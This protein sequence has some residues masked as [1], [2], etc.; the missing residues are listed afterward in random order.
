MAAITIDVTPEQVATM[1][2][3]HEWYGI[4]LAAYDKTTAVGTNGKTATVKK[5]TASKAK[6]DPIEDETEAD[7]DSERREELTGSTLKELKQEAIDLG[8][9]TAKE[10]VGVKKDDLIEMI[11]AAELDEDDDDSDDEDEDDDAADDDDSDADDDTDD[12]EGPTEEEL[13]E[14]SARELR[15]YAKENYGPVAKEE[16]FNIVKASKEDLIEFILGGEDEDADDDDDADSDDD[17]DDDTDD[18]DGDDP[19]DDEDALTEEDLNEMS[20]GEL[21]K[22]LKEE[23]GGKWT[24][25]DTKEVLIKKIIDTAEVPF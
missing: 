18:E 20:V 17:Q 4:I 8:A 21:R 9:A 15:A 19:D 24:P 25:K 7:A 1:R 14:M 16:G 12:D 22:L 11:L 6:A 2:I 5:T 23:F 13:N 3:Q 10:L